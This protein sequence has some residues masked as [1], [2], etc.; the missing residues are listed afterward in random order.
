MCRYTGNRERSA[1]TGRFQGRNLIKSRL[2]QNS[3]TSASE[4]TPMS[5]MAETLLRISGEKVQV[6]TS[7]NVLH[8]VWGSVK[9]LIHSCLTFTCGSLLRR[10]SLEGTSSLL[11][12][13]SSYL[14][15]GWTRQPRRVL[16]Q[17][18]FDQHS[19]RTMQRDLCTL[20]GMHIGPVV[21]VFIPQPNVPP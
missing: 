14:R 1:L 4:S 20:Q 8:T 12:Q 19:S 16:F 21:V 6:L 13:N 18:L 9:E 7:D 17:P 5:K 2:R 10:L 11:P 15:D 3:V